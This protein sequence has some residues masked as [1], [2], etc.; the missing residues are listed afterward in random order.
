[1]IQTPHEMDPA[2]V[3][4]EQKEDWENP[5]NTSLISQDSVEDLL[6]KAVSAYHKTL[7]LLEHK[8]SSIPGSQER[9]LANIGNRSFHSGLENT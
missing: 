9:L 4:N 7:I 6:Y 5:W 1:M 3:L 8:I 2:K